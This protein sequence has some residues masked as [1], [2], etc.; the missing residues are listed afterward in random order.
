[1][2]LPAS[3]EADRLTRFTVAAAALQDAQ[4]AARREAAEVL[5]GVA[6]EWLA[7]ASV[8][9]KQRLRQAQA[10]INALCMYIRSPFRLAKRYQRLAHGTVRRSWSAQ[11]KRR[12]RA[13]VEA[14]RAEAHLRGGILRAIAARLHTPDTVAPV[15]GGK[16]PQQHGG[17]PGSWSALTYDFSG[18][19]FFYPVD[20]SGAYWGRR[21]V[22]EG[23]VF[24][25]S[26]DFSGGF[27][28]RKARFAGCAW[29]SEVSFDRCMFNRVADFSQGHY[30]RPVNRRF[31]TYTDEAW[32]HGSTHKNTVDYSGSIYRGWASFADNTYRADAVFSGCLYRRDAMFQG[33]RYGGRAALDHCTY[34]GVAFMRECVYERDADMS[35]CT[36]YG[37]AAATECP[38]EQARFDASVYYGDVNYAGSVFCHH[39]DFTCSAYYGGADFGGCVYR[40]GLSVSGSAFHGPVNFGGSECGKKS[41]CANAVFTG[42]VTLT[43]TVFRKKVI[44]EESAFLAS[45]DFSAA[46]FS[47]RIPGFTECIF[48]PG[49]QY[50]FPQPVTSPPPGSRLLAPW[51]VRRL[52]YFRQQVQAFTHPAAD[53]PEVLEAARQRVR[54]LKKQLHAWVFAMQDPRYQHPGFEKIR[55]I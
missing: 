43:G 50:A 16:T 34:E 6:D 55:G 14:F 47:G 31:C 42:L 48:T 11:K 46:D 27:F 18:A 21:A 2:V 5:I 45:T 28:R 17:A 4:V 8:P 49:E 44:F 26:A 15:S 41:Y 23:C 7:D 3:V 35:G 19:V 22:F 38:G 24:Y 36:Y 13:S 51:E 39:P 54:V 9:R 10:A 12:L 33:S 25:G 37:R 29:R 1:M 30:K 32:L 20:F 52:D 53:D 40:R